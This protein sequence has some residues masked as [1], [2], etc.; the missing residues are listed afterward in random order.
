M[1]KK[2]KRLKEI[3][4]K[5]DS[6]EKEYKELKKELQGD[7]EE[8][9]VDKV[10]SRYGQVYIVE[11]NRKSLNKER[12]VEKGYDLDDC[13]KEYSYSYLNFKPASDEDKK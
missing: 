10:Q 13:Y 3:K 11:Q 5:L 7:L 12:L 9:G 4:E 8:R 6:L 2:V 1:I